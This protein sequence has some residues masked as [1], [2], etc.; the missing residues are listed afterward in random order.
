MTIVTIAAPTSLLLLAARCSFATALTS[1]TDKEWWDSVSRSESDDDDP[2]NGVPRYEN[3]YELFIQLCYAEG[4]ER[5][6]SDRVFEEAER[7]SDEDPC[8]CAGNPSW[9]VECVDGN[10]TALELDYF[11]GICWG[12]DLNAEECECLE[13]GLYDEDQTWD[14]EA[15]VQEYLPPPIGLSLADLDLTA[16][17]NLQVLRAPHNGLRGVLSREMA[18]LTSLR[19]LDLSDNTIQSS[20]VPDLA[21]L[22]SLQILDLSYNS[23]MT[24]GIPSDF[25]RLDALSYFSVKGTRAMT[26]AVPSGFLCHCAHL[27]G[28]ESGC[29][30]SAG[31]NG[32]GLRLEDDFDM[33]LTRGECQGTVSL[34]LAAHGLVGKVPSTLSALASSLTS[35]D[36][37]LNQMTGTIPFTFSKLTKLETLR[38]GFNK[39]SGDVP[40]LPPTLKTLQLVLDGETEPW[41]N[42]NYVE[43]AGEVLVACDEV[44][45]ENG[46]LEAGPSALTFTV[47]LYNNQ[48]KQI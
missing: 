29:S 36:L 7:L 38:L 16:L 27:E 14:D 45:S 34:N 31:V 44:Y 19:T 24:G 1:E 15:C 39:L 30:L 13:N 25:E 40:P 6:D 20:I 32:N 41:W 23:A 4:A 28:T 11:A 42:L 17:T 5:G 47:S 10:V 26:G 18:R 33:A 21:A 2:E 22:S 37:S 8:R 9:K 43:N 12:F 3:F 46:D 48:L 35:L